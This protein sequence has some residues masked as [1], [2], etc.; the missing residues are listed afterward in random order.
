MLQLQ[1]RATSAHGGATPEHFGPLR[2][3][4][5]WLLARLNPPLAKCMAPKIA[6]GDS[7]VLHLLE[8]E[9]RGARVDR[10]PDAL[11]CLDGDVSLAPENAAVYREHGAWLCGQHRFEEAVSC[12]SQALELTPGVAG[13]HHDLADAY[14][15]LDRPEHA[16]HHY[17]QTVALDPARTD[18][19][20]NLGILLSKR[21][22]YLEAETLLRQLIAAAPNFIEARQNLAQV[23]VAAGRMHEALQACT[24][25]I[26]LEPTNIGFR[27][28]L[29]IVHGALGHEAEA[30][31]LYRAWH[32]EDPSN[33]QVRHLYSAYC[34]NAV[35][36]VASP[37]YVRETFDPFA[38][39]FE[40]TLA[41]LDYRVPSLVGEA[42]HVAL[43]A[44]SA[45]LRIADAGC[46]TGLCAPF[47]HP[48][49]RHLVGIDLSHRMLEQAEGKALYDE[50]HE[51]E[52]VEFL[53][54]STGAFDVI[55][56]ADT[57]CY[58]GV[59]T[60]FAREAH[61]ALVGGGWLIFTVE[62]L[63]DDA[64]ASPWR[65]RTHGRYAHRRE[66]VEQTLT[67]NGFRLHSIEQVVLRTEARTPVTG[68]LVTAIVG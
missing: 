52:L 17:R 3:R 66:Y 16:E 67:A 64:D 68:W 48:F 32:E 19:A 21:A 14:W 39:D 29:G 53:A 46:G 26:A 42:L 45:Q 41:K 37:D 30:R 38:V 7:P 40:R 51:R 63:I 10:T 50:L 25:G 33:T 28:L 27:Q 9:Q 20:N 11:A 4:E 6:A 65:L 8:A 61:R 49:A 62:A 56:S 24:D 31:E 22:A 23:Y 34:G 57:L 58:F 35:P 18:A 2:A 44:T 60:D 47:L 55:V 36:D 59:L 5:N 15:M 13:I 54:V 43:G 1:F 12:F